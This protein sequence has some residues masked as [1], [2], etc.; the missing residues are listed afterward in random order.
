MSQG[1]VGRASI[2]Q[3]QMEAQAQKS[4]T[5]DLS[6]V[7]VCSSAVSPVM[8]PLV[9]TG[10]SLGISGVGKSGTRLQPT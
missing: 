4:V 6:G 8:M 9:F 5:S 1:V 10:I 2:G 7:N 3:A